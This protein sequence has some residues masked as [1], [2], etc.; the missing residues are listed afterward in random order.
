MIVFCVTYILQ[1]Q[2]ISIGFRDTSHSV[3][4][5][6]CKHE[7]WFTCYS[8]WT[9]K[10]W[11]KAIKNQLKFCRAVAAKNYNFR[12]GWWQTSQFFER[13]TNFKQSY[14]FIKVHWSITHFYSNNVQMQQ[15][16]EGLGQIYSR[17]MLS[18]QHS[19]LDY[20][21]Q[22]RT[23][24]CQLKPIISIRLKLQVN[25]CHTLGAILVC[26]RRWCKVLGGFISSWHSMKL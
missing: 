2:K 1:I 17:V 16:T 6:I 9:F 12:T 18:A 21:K 19:R 10:V 15:K 22:K 8:Y 13:C 26:I 23:I 20:D 11:Y 5:C 7:L 3:N 24:T 4:F 25:I 14:C